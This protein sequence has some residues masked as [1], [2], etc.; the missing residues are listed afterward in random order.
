MTSKRKNK[1]DPSNPWLAPGIIKSIK[2]KNNLYKQFCQTT[3]S[4][5]RVS[6]HQKFKNHRHQIV[7]LNCLCKEDYFKAY[8][9]TNKN[10][11]KKSVFVIKL[12]SILRH[13]K[14]YLKNLL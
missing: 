2:I 6:L 14:M 10:D 8:F 4:A 1:Q 5:Q 12:S 7:T 11:S 3:N 13:L 9:E